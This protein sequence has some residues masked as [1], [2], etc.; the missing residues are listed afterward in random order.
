LRPT[1]DEFII[2]DAIPSIHMDEKDGPDDSDITPA[3]V[4]ADIVGRIPRRCIVQH[5]NSD[6]LSSVADTDASHMAQAPEVAGSVESVEEKGRGKCKK[7]KNMLYAG[8][9]R[10][11]ARDGRDMPCKPGMDIGC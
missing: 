10:H 1:D 2:E 9:W 8:W 7:K 11:E 3:E 5:A 6:G 4:V